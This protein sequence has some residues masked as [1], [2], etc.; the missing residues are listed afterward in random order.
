MSSDIHPLTPKLSDH[1]RSSAAIASCSTIVEELLLNA[2]DAQASKIEVYLD[3][4][5]FQIKVTDNGMH[6]Y[7]YKFWL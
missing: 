6:R 2:L 7:K 5:N 4:A 1:I 3:I